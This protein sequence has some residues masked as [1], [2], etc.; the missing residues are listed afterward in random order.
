VEPQEPP[1]SPPEPSQDLTYS[2]EELQPPV[3]PP[4][5]PP[6]VEPTPVE[7]TPV[8]EPPI[9]EPP[10]APPTV[11]VTFDVRRGRQRIAITAGGERHECL[12]PCTLDL[13]P[14]DVQ[15]GPPAGRWESE[16]SFTVPGGPAVARI[17]R[18]RGRRL[19]GVGIGL[20]AGGGGLAAI[21]LI[22]A[23]LTSPAIS[24]L[25]F[26]GG[27]AA[28]IALA[29]PGTLGFVAGLVLL[30]I[31]PESYRVQLE[32]VQ[33]Q[34]QPTST[35]TAHIRPPLSLSRFMPTFAASAAS[36]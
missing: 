21:G 19:R 6:P 11:P 36:F 5:E 31:A 32:A 28:G 14:G 15:I 9:V 8:E 23:V 34:E 20:A 26:E 30:A 10:P 35:G 7:P 12:T 17:V 16:V 25:G 22:V 29:V 13:Q 1:T 27:D 24:N 2:Q 18:D 4:V 3:E 33:Q